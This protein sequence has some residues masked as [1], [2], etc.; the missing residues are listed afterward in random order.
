MYGDNLGEKLVRMYVLR[1]G[2]GSWLVRVT[3][4]SFYR[5]V[6]LGRLE[7]YLDSAL[8]SSSLIFVNFHMP[9]LLAG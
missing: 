8:I 3:A 7:I 6:Y 2:H 9:I 5:L 4:L 1:K